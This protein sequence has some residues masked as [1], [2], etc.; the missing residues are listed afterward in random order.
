MDLQQRQIILKNLLQKQNITQDEVEIILTLLS[1]KAIQ[2]TLTLFLTR[3]DALKL[4]QLLDNPPTIEKE[5][6]SLIQVPVLYAKALIDQNLLVPRG[7]FG[8]GKRTKNRN[9]RT[10]NRNKRTKNRNKWTKK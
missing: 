3:D 2:E 5:L 7:V 6:F 9:K 4:K 10:K 8:G 1:M